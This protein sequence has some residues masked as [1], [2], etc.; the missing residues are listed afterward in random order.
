MAFLA[1]AGGLT[2]T[3]KPST[4]QRG[5]PPSRILDFSW[6]KALNMKSARGDENTPCVS[7]LQNV[8]HYGLSVVRLVMGEM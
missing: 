1:C 4:S 3:G 2:S 5:S 6:P 7:Y 8:S